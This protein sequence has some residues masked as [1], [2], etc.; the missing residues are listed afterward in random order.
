MSEFK[1]LN[2]N[3]YNRPMECAKCGGVMIFAGVGEYHCEDC[4]AVD[5]DDYGKV[6]NYLEAHRGATAA[7]VEM[8][9]GV[10]QRTIRNLLKEDRLEISADSVAFLRCEICGR[11][12]RS[13]RYCP[14]CL[15]DSNRRMEEEQRRKRSAKM[16]GHSMQQQS[17][18][19]AKR[20]N[21]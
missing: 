17:Q 1:N 8:F 19:G 2:A 3:P 11:N 18:E 4:D 12:I 5:Y 20:F 9:T 16:Q 7:E 6:R 15:T 21:R 10:S 13:G 14:K